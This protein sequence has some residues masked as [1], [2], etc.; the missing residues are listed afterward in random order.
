MCHQ[1][2]SKSPKKNL[3]IQATRISPRRKRK[4]TSLRCWVCLIQSPY[5]RIRTH[6]HMEPQGISQAINDDFENNISRKWGYPYVFTGGYLKFKVGLR[7]MSRPILSKTLGL[8][9]VAH[10]VFE[11]HLAK[12]YE[13]IGKCI[14]NDYSAVT[15]ICAHFQLRSKVIEHPKKNIH[16]SKMMVNSPMNKL[17]PDQPQLFPL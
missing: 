10:M 8:N 17:A 13:F 14:I 6:P 1:G 2:L 11:H 16:G 3:N 7:S 12:P 15:V 4:C 5:N 9:C